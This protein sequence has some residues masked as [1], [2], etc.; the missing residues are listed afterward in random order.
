[1]SAQ[2]SSKSRD[3][4]L[5]PVTTPS[6][7]D[8]STPA[9]RPPDLDH[10]IDDLIAYLAEAANITPAE[11]FDAV[12]KGHVLDLP[13]R[14]DRLRPRLAAGWNALLRNFRRP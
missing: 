3:A 4:H 12:A 13:A 9:P 7:T 8:P 5:A 2:L 14:S 1:M 6:T 11:A 10:A